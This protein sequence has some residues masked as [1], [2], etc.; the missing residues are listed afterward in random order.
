MIYKGIYDIFTYSDLEKDVRKNYKE[1]DLFFIVDNKIY[2]LSN[3]KK[4]E[5]KKF[6]A[7]YENMLIR[8]VTDDIEDTCV[9]V[10]EG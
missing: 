5:N 10:Y 7:V 9:E 2:V 1:D 8:F 3:F 6:D 4:S